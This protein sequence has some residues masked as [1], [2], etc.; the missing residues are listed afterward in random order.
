MSSKPSKTILE[1]P[2]KMVLFVFI[3]SG[4]TRE[5]TL[6]DHGLD[7]L[8]AIELAMQLEEDLGYVISAET[9]TQFQK[10]KHYI[11]YIEQVEGFKKDT[12]GQ[13]PLA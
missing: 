4:V 11:N 8:D 2:I 5:S 6:A 7:S 9:L 3:P 10:V 13:A 1:P 12:N